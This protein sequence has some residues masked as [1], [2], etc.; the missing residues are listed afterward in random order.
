MGPSSAS[1]PMANEW[2]RMPW[3]F[4]RLAG[5]ALFVIVVLIYVTFADLSVLEP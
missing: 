2:I 5:T 3:R 1:G 4:A